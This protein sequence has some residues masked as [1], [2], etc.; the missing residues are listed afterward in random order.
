M[1]HTKRQQIKEKI[2]AAIT[3]A[4]EVITNLTEITRPVAPD[5][6]IGRL[7]R[8]EAI[9]SKSINEAVLNSATQKLAKLKHALAKIDDLE[10]GICMD[11]GTAIPLGRIMIV[12][13]INLCVNCAE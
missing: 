5:N 8:M 6:A 12:P 9:S 2:K 10:F 3:A 11:C 4:E 1:E 13:E 7:S